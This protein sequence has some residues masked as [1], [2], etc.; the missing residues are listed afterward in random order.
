MQPLHES[1]RSSPESERP[2]RASS[3]GHPGALA[4]PRPAALVRRRERLRLP[5]DRSSVVQ[6]LAAAG[7]G[8]ST[9][10]SIW[11][12]DLRQAGE[13]VLWVGLTAHETAS[14]PLEALI[15]ESL[16]LTDETGEPVD[17]GGLPGI[18]EATVFI[19][20][21]HHLW[22]SADAEW[23]V[24]LV[25]NR[26]P[27][28]RIVLAG[29]YAP[30]SLVRIGLVADIVELRSGDLAFTQREIADFLAVRGVH[31][32]DA[33]LALTARRTE[34]W[35]AALSLLAGWLRNV[36]GETRLPE[37]FL[38]D[39]RAI[40]D[41]L[42][43]EVLDQL[44]PD[45]RRFLLI[46]SV[47]DSLS[48]PLAVHLTGRE[49]SGDI[50]DGLE[51]HTALLS[52]TTD[53][54]PRYTFHTTL[55]TYLRAELRRRDFGGMQ[56]AQRDAADWYRQTG[57]A[58]IAL[59]L[60]LAADSSDNAGAIAALATLIEAEGARLVFHGSG[61]LVQRALD[62][63]HDAGFETA[64]THVLAALAVA[65]YL[66][67]P[68]RVAFHLTAA[69][70]GID[71]APAAIG[72]LHAALAILHTTMPVDAGTDA[73]GAAAASRTLVPLASIEVLDARLAEASTEAGP[74][75]TA[76][77]SGQ[78]ASSA[79]GAASAVDASTGGDAA[80][81][82]FEVALF[83]AIARS[84]ISAVRGDDAAALR[85][86]N[87]AIASATASGCTWLRIVLRDAAVDAASRSG[88][89]TEAHD[90]EDR[91]AELAASVNGRGLG[92]VV[93][94]RI[95]FAIASTAFSRCEPYDFHRLD[96]VLGG[97][98]AIVDPAL[99]VPASVL[100][101]LVGVD[102]GTRQREAFDEL[103]VLLHSRGQSHPAAVAAASHRYIDLALRVHDRYRGVRSVELVAS[104][105]GPESLEAA[106]GAAMLAS[107]VGRQAHAEEMLSTILDD[108]EATPVVWHSSTPVFAW[109]L[110]AEW[111]E[112]GGRSTIADGRLLRA[113]DAA[114]RLRLRRPFVALHGAG[115]AM[116][117]PRLGRFGVLES[118]AVSVVEASR[119][120]R[121]AVAVHRPSDVAAG[122]TPKE[123]EILRE[124]PRHQSVGDIALKQRLSPNTV[125]T[126]M[127]SIYQK[128]G[129]TG[130]TEAVELAIAQGLL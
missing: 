38:S 68:S 105:L 130:R 107:S 46:A 79:F 23:L 64:T 77:G 8:K 69:A 44:E 125:K 31:L 110:L 49:D 98:S 48:V 89:W 112:R 123:R 21:I 28:L 81:D 103:D 24:R 121:P 63:I 90:H 1:N 45:R 94:G 3:L 70:A 40:G 101:L 67:D 54:E 55:L 41:Y 6:V 30:V 78:G 127:R 50:L 71:D 60:L 75:E 66:P 126:H 15:A 58:D 106:V 42:V 4:P 119:R 96:E 100:R 12:D 118:F 124:L 39:H 26:A 76:G 114:E 83:A 52:H 61:V 85:T 11:A 109:L 14:L 17:G 35:A 115:A 53:G 122:F 93:T 120:L 88:R 92:D 65:P 111:A 2:A 13:R 128:L 7:A 72:A 25:V 10:L 22:G 36:G 117:E 59:E 37:Q 87:T 56:R 104:V 91:L 29:R 80:L 5:T 9:L 86:L 95:Q 108:R 18:G 73:A 20:D 43:N 97:G 99:V 129:A 16:R 33:D 51:R 113:L 27:G 116:L 32:S 62:R 84:R 34:G 57:R 102:D 19:D 47:V 82:A 74:G